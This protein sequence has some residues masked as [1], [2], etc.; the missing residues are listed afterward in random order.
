[1]NNHGRHSIQDLAVK[2]AHKIPGSS[3]HRKLWRHFCHRFVEDVQY[4]LHRDGEFSATIDDVA[5]RRLESD[6]GAIGSNTG[7]MPD[8]SN[9][10]ALKGY[11]LRHF[12]R[13]RLLGDL[14]AL[15]QPDWLEYRIAELFSRGG[16]DK[17]MSLT[18]RS[19]K[20]VKAASLGGGPGYDY[21]ALSA[22]SEYR[23]GPSLCT[24]V[25]EY[26][27]RWRE[28]VSS[29]QRATHNVMRN[30][31]HKCGFSQC[32][33]TL[34]L[35]NMINADVADTVDSTQI[36]ACCYCVA[37]NAV[38]LRDRDWAFFRHLFEVSRNGTM[39]FFT[40][41]THRLWPELINIARTAKLR[42][43][44]PHLRCGKVGWQFV[45][46]KD[47][48][49]P[50]T[51]YYSTAIDPEAYKRFKADNDAHMSRLERGWKREK[52]KARGYA[53]TATREDIILPR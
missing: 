35:D 43:A 34:P 49:S 11:T 5:A 18:P 33:I 14:I 23:Q 9:Q 20:S 13:A 28:I 53:T 41:T 30:E 52:R 44:T 38:A 39:F 37:E 15:D 32:D 50:G 51:Q 24:T 1:M 36:F 10:A 8:F 4:D 47:G 42:L 12:G 26:E 21:V 19:N 3:K 46:L 22:L 45:A 40:E 6:L 17:S 27:T 2:A 48:T 7:V 31:R 25:Y 16:Q 29:V